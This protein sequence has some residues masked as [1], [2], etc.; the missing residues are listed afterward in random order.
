MV[1]NMDAI[2]RGTTKYFVDRS[3]IVSLSTVNDRVLYSAMITK[4]IEEKSKKGKMH[5]AFKMGTRA[6]F[7]G[8]L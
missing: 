2:L 8:T 5:K 1:G 7:L 4:Y 6:S 3:N